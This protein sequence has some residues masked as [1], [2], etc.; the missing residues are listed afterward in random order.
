MCRR[1]HLLTCL[2]LVQLCLNVCEGFVARE[3]TVELLYNKPANVI[4]SHSSADLAPE[5]DASGRMTVIKT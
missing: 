2:S 4:T 1:L 5:A 3:K